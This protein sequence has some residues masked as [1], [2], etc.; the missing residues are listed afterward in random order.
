MVWK[1]SAWLSLARCAR[2]ALQKRLFA[3]PDD[4]V[5]RAPSREVGLQLRKPNEG[6]SRGVSIASMSSNCISSC[7]P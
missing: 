7:V 6:Q 3:Y 5:G 2:S 1:C 4:D